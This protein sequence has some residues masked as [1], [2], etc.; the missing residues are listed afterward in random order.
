MKDLFGNDS[1]L[2]AKDTQADQHRVLLALALLWSPYPS[3]S[4]YQLMLKLDFRQSDGRHFTAEGVKRTLRQLREQHLVVES[5]QRQGYYRVA[6]AQRNA[7]YEELLNAVKAPVLQSA[8]YET[9]GFKPSNAFFS[10]SLYD[11]EATVAIVRFALLSRTSKP[12]I[13]RRARW[14]NTS[15]ACTTTNAPSPKASLVKVMQS[16]CLQQKS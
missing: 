5:A 14:K 6:E 1:L 9:V 15:S 2:P 11:R 8:L 3:A 10:W 16:V 7:L 4:L 13:E 12:E